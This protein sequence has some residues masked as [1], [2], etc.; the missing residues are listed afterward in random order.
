MAFRMSLD[1]RNALCLDALTYLAGTSGTG[2][3]AQLTI[4]AGDQPGSAESAGTGGT[5]CVI[6]GIGWGTTTT[7]TSSF[8]TTGGYSGTAGSTG[9]PGWARLETINASGTCRIDGDVGTSG[10]NVFTINVASIVEDGVVT[11]TAAD[12][13]LT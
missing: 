6:A 2:G 4:R 10:T 7:G 13:Y 5:L 9:T 8:A 12:I 11:L 1:M 3:T